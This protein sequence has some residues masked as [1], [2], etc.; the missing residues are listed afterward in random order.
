MLYLLLTVA[1]LAIVAQVVG[2][3]LDR[4]RAGPRF[5]VIC[6]HAA[7]AVFSL[8]LATS[9]LSLAF[10][11]LVFGILLSRKAYG[12][13]TKAMVA[14]MAPGETELV[15]AS[16]HLA[17]TG[18]IAGGIGTALGG[19]LIWVFGVAWLPVAAAVFFVC[20]GV[21][22][23]R[24]PP[25]V[26]EARVESV[27]I[28]VETPDEVRRA[29]PAVATIRA[30]EG[31]L[32][33]LL[34][35]SIKRGGGDEWIFVAALLAAGIGTFAGTIVAPRLYR[36]F[37]SDGIVVLTLLI[38]GVMSAFGVLTIGSLS[39]VAI[40]LAIGLGGSVAT[41]AMDAI[42][43]G[44]PHL[45]ARPHH[46]PQRAAVPIGQRHRRG[47]RRAGVPGSTRRVRRSRCAPHRCR[48]H[49]CVAAATLVAP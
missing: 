31:A 47:H 25:V 12:L 1:P 3:A 16:G 43:G 27:I 5:V 34:A 18:T 2:P 38:P 29:A 23:S 44:V 19:G 11:P 26:V 13:A 39:I 20:A 36:G 8:L 37:S 40:A 30:A 45:I 32:T 41:R 33:F 24:I 46:L 35:L 28:R 48:H 15:T 17:R 21:L 4:I 22:A 42:Y 10:Y 9:L 6:S 49:L 7:R 14:Q